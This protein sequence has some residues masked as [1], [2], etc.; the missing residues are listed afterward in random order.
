MCKPVVFQNIEPRRYLAIRAR[1]RAQADRMEI[2][3]DRGTA[4]SENFTCI[5][6]YDEAA[7]TLTIQYTKKPSWYPEG[8][9]ADKIRALVTSL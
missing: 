2:D 1:L 5:W 9:A 4:S 6:A 3:G 8:L 7:R